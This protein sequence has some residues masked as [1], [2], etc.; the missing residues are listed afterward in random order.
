MGALLET[1]EHDAAV[2]ELEALAELARNPDEKI[3]VLLKAAKIAK[4]GIQKTATLQR[5][6][7]LNPCN[8]K[9]ISALAADAGSSSDGGYE[10][11]MKIWSEGANELRRAI[12]K[13]PG[14]SYHYEQLAVCLA[15]AGEIDAERLA[16]EALGSLEPLSKKQSEHLQTLSQRRSSNASAPVF[17]PRMFE[18]AATVSKTNPVAGVWQD[19]A[20]K[21][22]S[23][24][25]SATDIGFSKSEKIR[26]R[27]L[28]ATY[29]A[30]AAVFEAS[31]CNVGDF[32]VSKNRDDFVRVLGVESPDVCIAENTARLS[33]ETS[34]YR[35]GWALAQ[36]K[37]GTA[38]LIEGGPEEFSMWMAAAAE[39]AGCAKPKFAEQRNTGD[40]VKLLGKLPRKVKKSL[41][42]R[43]S[44]LASLEDPGS[45]WRA[46]VAFGCRIGLALSQSVSTAS[47]LAEAPVRL[48]LLAWA[49]SEDFA[50]FIKRGE[51]SST[52]G[53]PK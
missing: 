33:D 23:L 15:G 2:I 49:A 9:A 34:L 12:A 42:E 13:D 28:R 21:V 46:Y 5:A 10:A 32:Y 30:L 26:F 25:P 22:A 38:P 7:S 50:T 24:Q 48:D 19:I 44:L 35:V 39:I 18:V 47:K 51:S 29:P 20:G 31:K 37:N 8:V 41:A 27:D 1:G 17:D 6:V 4:A 40:A 43:Q 45:L 52:E 16:L 3:D 53:G 11:Q 36:I 14:D